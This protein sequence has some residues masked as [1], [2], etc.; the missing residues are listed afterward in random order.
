M[1]ET[2]TV[3]SRIAGLADG[4]QQVISGVA[5]GA[6]DVTRGLSGDR[7]V[8]TPEELKEAAET[9]EGGDLKALHS[10]TAVGTVT[11]AGYVNGEGVVYEARVDDAELA[12][13]I[14]NADLPEELANKL[15]G[16]TRRRR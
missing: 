3:T 14:A 6:G 1:P 11:D 13:A 9:L 15:G 2:S 8:W 10:E 16:N 4:P 5:V 12:D 7:K